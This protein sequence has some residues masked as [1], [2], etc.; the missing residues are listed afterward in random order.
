MDLAGNRAVLKIP[1]HRGK[2][3]VVRRIQIVDDRLGQQVVG[4][5][6]VQI[7]R[8]RLGLR[9]VADGIKACVRPKLREQAD[10]VVAQ[11]A[12][13]KLLRPAAFGVEMAEEHHHERRKL[14]MF[15]R[16]NRFSAPRLVENPR[17]RFLGTKI[18]VAMFQPV[19]GQPAALRVEI[20][21]PFFQRADERAETADVHIRRR[22]QL[23][24]P[25]VESGGRIHSQRLVGAECGKHPRRMALV[26]ERTVIFQVVRR[27]VRGADDLDFEFFEQALGREIRGGELRV[28]FL[29]NF[30]G[31]LLAQQIRDAE[32]PFQFEVRPMIQ[33]V[34]ECV[35]NRF[36]PGFEF[37][38]R[39]GV[40]GDEFFGDAVGAHR[41]PFVMVAF[42]P[43]FK[44]VFELAVFGNVFRRQ[45]AVIIKN[46][47]VC[48]V[49]M[50]KPARAFG[51]QQK[52]F[53]DEFHRWLVFKLMLLVFSFSIPCP[54]RAA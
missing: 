19:I 17:R 53:V 54:S 3:I 5:Q 44:E 15:Q 31:G 23:L 40:A 16:R 22:G 2:H 12:E 32:I 45:M 1:D 38:L 52:I 35:R 50:V 48:G 47:L 11:G 18:R 36:G 9:E 30:R 6:F 8:E 14:G 7:G 29:P 20:I 42:Q 26:G 51:A 24:H 37:L 25:L 27:V 4:I 49:F 41:P 46:R 43:D 13:V 10:V 39:R 33:R 28:G 21:M 34:A